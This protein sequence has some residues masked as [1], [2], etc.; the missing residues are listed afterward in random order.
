MSLQRAPWWMYVVGASFLAYFAMVDYTFWSGPEPVGIDIEYGQHDAVLRRNR[1]RL[2]SRAR[3]IATR[4]SPG[5]SER[6][7][8]SS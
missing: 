7:G 2:A 1:A 3:R 4:R 8:C 5:H 6:L